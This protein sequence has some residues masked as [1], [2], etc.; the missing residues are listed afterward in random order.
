LRPPF[1]KQMRRWRGY[2]YLRENGAPY[3]QLGVSSRP[4]RSRRCFGPFRSRR[5]A[6]LV[7]EAVADHFALARCPVDEVPL[8][9]LPLLRAADAG[10]LCG[11]YFDGRCAGPCSGRIADEDYA[12][13]I[14]RCDALLAGSDDGSLRALE[15]R[16]ESVSDSERE[17]AAVKSQLR[18]AATLR[19]VF[20]YAATLRAAEPLL[21][22][23]LLLPGAPAAR[24]VAI[25]TR[26]GVCFDVLRNEPADAARVLTLHRRRTGRVGPNGPARL[27]ITAADALCL[28]VRHMAQAS[29]LYRFVPGE[30]LG[31]L[32][33]RGLRALAFGTG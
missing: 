30:E 7:G 9:P 13:R 25:P 2:C 8:R 16:L 14:A 5:L 32:D 20:D 33:A 31:V 19:M 29:G 17:T 12:S 4:S 27:P 22:G 11:R 24:K 18:Q 6:E 26:R 3:G 28:V 23:L 10:R 1:N 15:G 21:D